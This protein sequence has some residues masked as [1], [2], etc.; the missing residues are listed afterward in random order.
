MFHCTHPPALKA[1]PHASPDY[2][3]AADD[4]TRSCWEPSCLVS[5]ALSVKTGCFSDRLFQ[6]IALDDSEYFSI[7][8][9]YLLTLSQPTASL[10]SHLRWPLPSFLLASDNLNAMKLGF[11]LVW[12]LWSKCSPGIIKLHLLSAQPRVSSSNWRYFMA[13]WSK[14]EPADFADKNAQRHNARPSCFISKGHWILQY[15]SIVNIEF[16]IL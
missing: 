4:K 14:R 3:E 12:W 9:K 6:S 1:S 5:V 11:I 15:I 13:L 10:S 2:S 8:L 7:C 16:G